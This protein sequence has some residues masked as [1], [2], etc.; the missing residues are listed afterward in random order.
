[1]L[2]VDDEP[3]NRLAIGRHLIAEDYV[4]H[5]AADG[6]VALA[7]VRRAV[8]DL[9]V[10]D[11]EMPV[12]DGWMAIRAVRALPPPLGDVAVLCYSAQRPDAARL[13]AAGF[14]GVLPKPC[15]GATLAAAIAPWSPTGALADIERLAQA[16]GA[17]EIAALVVRFRD[18]LAQALAELDGDT[19]RASAHRI[20]G[21]AGTLGFA[22]VG[23]SFLAL[24]E[25]DDSMRARARRDA[26]AALR[27]IDRAGF[28]RDLP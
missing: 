17:A 14:D 6:A 23:H 7:C 12:L 25:G 21:I 24:S 4:V 1:M 16:F 27:Q 28:D 19:D 8:P 20:A 15:D 5:Y 22:R 18:H 2:V 10:M 13:R 11:L 26:A 3:A 9:I